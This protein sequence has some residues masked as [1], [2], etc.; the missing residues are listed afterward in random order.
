M[1]LITRLLLTLILLV[2]AVLAHA[3]GYP[4]KPLRIVVGFTAGGPSDIVARIVAQQLG[5]AFLDTDLRTVTEQERSIADIFERDGE[6]LFRELETRQIEAC[7]ALEAQSVISLGGGAVL[8]ERNRE[9]LRSRSFVV[10]LRASVPTL[11]ARVGHAA[12][13]PL[14]VDD[15]VGRITRIDAERRPLYAATAHEIIDVDDLRSTQV[16]DGVRAAFS[17]WRP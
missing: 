17:R 3:Q 13:R 1:N 2:S 16:A 12:S 10:W 11:L 8:A 6:A 14:I 15:P 7:L 5:L 9:L 4:S